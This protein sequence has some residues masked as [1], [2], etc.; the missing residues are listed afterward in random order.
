MG[1]KTIHEY[2]QEARFFVIF[3]ENIINNRL[4]KGNK[5]SKYAMLKFR[6]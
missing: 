2:F 4:I 3:L 5:L 6:F 1:P